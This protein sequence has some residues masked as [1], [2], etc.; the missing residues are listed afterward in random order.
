MPVNTKLLSTEVQHFI[1]QNAGTDLNVLIL[2]GSPFK[3]LSIQEIAQQI[4]GFRKAL[5]K[6]PLWHKTPH[7]LF[8]TK[9]QLEQSSSE[10]TARYK[11]ELVSG[12]CL[13]DLTGGFGVDATFFSKKFKEVIHCEQNE[14]LSTMVAH[15]C[16]QL[17]VKNVQTA[18]G[19]SLEILKEK[20][21]PIDWIY[22]DPSR[23][24]LFQKKVFL[25]ED[26]TPHVPKNLTLLMSKSRRVLIKYAPML[27]ISSAVKQLKYVV[28][29]HVIAVQNDVK[30]VLFVLEKT[31]PLAPKIHTCNL[32]KNDRQTFEFTFGVSAKSNYSLPQKY[33]Y[34]PNAAIL[35]SGAFHQVSEK[36]KVNKLHPHTHLYTAENPVN[37]FP[38]RRFTIQLCTSY[39]RKKLSALLPDQKANITTRNFPETVAQIRKKTKLK[40][41]GDQYLFF[42]TDHRNKKTVLLCIKTP[43]HKN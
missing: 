31:K 30:E 2:K 26:C 22:L 25:V 32:L 36:F 5:T 16:K 3:D 34:E 13:M 17:G 6:L 42:T 38:G 9:T 10:L 37:N 35:K 23:R 29:I 21:N 11:S 39:D 15:N 19:D 12:D 40:E 24:N 43:P 1:R 20:T 8:P 27:D 41:G 18:C 7:V 14:V 4:A 33:L 28:E